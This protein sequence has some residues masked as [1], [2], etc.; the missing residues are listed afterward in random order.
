MRPPGGG[1]GRR[2]S[3]MMKHAFSTVSY[4][5]MAKTESNRQLVSMLGDSFDITSYCCREF[6]EAKA[7]GQLPVLLTAPAIKELVIDH[8][9]PDC[10]FFVARRTINPKSL[11]RVYSIPP[12][13][14]VLVVNNLYK[15]AVEVIEELQA[16]GVTHLRYTAHVPGAALERTFKYAITPNEMDLVPEEIP[17]VINIGTR[18]ISIMSIAQILFHYNNGNIPESILHERYNRYMMTLSA[19]LSRKYKKNILLQRQMNVLLQNYEAGTLITNESGLVTFCN[20]AAEKLLGKREV[21]GCDIRDLVREELLAKPG[22]SAFANIRDTLVRVSDT[23]YDLGGGEGFRIITLKEAREAQAV[24]A[25]NAGAPEA[26]PANGRRRA[27]HG[28]RFRFEDIVHR[29]PAM[30]RTVDLARRFARKDATILITGESGTGKELLAQSMHNDSLRASC[31]FIAVN[32]AA[33]SETLLESELFG[34]EDG[35]FTGARKGGRKGLFEMAEGGTLFL[36][37]LGDAPV[38]TQI[39]MLRVLQEREIMRIGSGRAIPVNVRIIAATNKDLL[40]QVRRGAFREDLYYRLNVINIH[41]PPLR[42]R[43]GDVA[44]LLRHFLDSFGTPADVLTPEASALL[45][46]HDWPGNIRELKNVAEY[47]A[48][49]HDTCVSLIPDIRRLLR[50][51]ARD[52]APGGEAGDGSGPA[53]GGE[54]FFRKPEMREEILQILQVMHEAR[55]SGRLLGRFTI[56]DILAERGAAMSIQQIKTRLD[57]LRDNGLI[58]TANGRGSVLTEAGEAYLAAGAEG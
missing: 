57:I 34:Y 53:G 30:A 22:G 16:M 41:L 4:D 44:L 2:L 43:R 32:C 10:T 1:G 47:I 12:M 24:P 31:P 33:L 58:L 52:G 46:G 5:A 26:R 55:D 36:D 49:T 39:K 54:L 6:V 23:S 8:L 19:N 25:A 13:S 9:P 17:N 35:A 42:E 40:E 29:S 18:L 7:P 11:G 51:D 37:E 3:A 27:A 56:R 15:N 21:V 14:D 50:L 38:A 48:T 45:N 20:T 28:A